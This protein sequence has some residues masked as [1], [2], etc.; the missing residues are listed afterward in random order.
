MISENCKDCNGYIIWPEYYRGQ[1]PLN[2]DGTIH[3]CVS[4]ETS[5]IIS[6]Q[7]KILPLPDIVYGHTRLL[8][9]LIQRINDL[10]KGL[11]KN[12]P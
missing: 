3:Y 10:E 6:N 5:N 12:D 1:R 7:T 4:T 8:A 11:S 2:L 9:K